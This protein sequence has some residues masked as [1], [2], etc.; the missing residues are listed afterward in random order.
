MAVFCGVTC[1]QAQRPQHFVTTRFY[2]SDAPLVRAVEPTEHESSHAN[3]FRT[4]SGVLKGDHS[5]NTWGDS[6]RGCLVICRC[7]VAPIV[8]CRNVCEVIR[9]RGNAV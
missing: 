8:A 5:L 9:R 1:H 6:G 4:L 3:L 7:F 2:K